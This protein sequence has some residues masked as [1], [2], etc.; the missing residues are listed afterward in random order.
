MTVSARTLRSST[1]PKQVKKPDNEKFSFPPVLWTSKG[2]TLWEIHDFFLC[3]T[4][5]WWKHWNKRRIAKGKRFKNEQ[6]KECWAFS[7]R[8]KVCVLLDTIEIHCGIQDK[9]FCNFVWR[10]VSIFLWWIKTWAK[11]CRTEWIGT[12]KIE[13]DKSD[14]KFC[15]WTRNFY[16]YC[17]CGKKKS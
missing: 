4:K 17:S 16:S 12:K 6:V 1:R 13:N 9:G 15:W 3:N 11:V 2:I 14:Q 7:F 5:K 8:L 10:S